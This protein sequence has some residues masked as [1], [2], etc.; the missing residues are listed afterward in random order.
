MR[1]VQTGPVTGL[2]A[3]RLSRSGAG[4][5][6]PADWVT[7]AR[8]TLTV[9]VAA[10]VVESLHRAVP[11]ALLVSFAAMAL[12]LDAVDG[13]VAR[14]T[15]TTVFGARLD[16]EVDAFLIAVLSVYVARSV[17]GWVLTIGLAR[18]VFGAA[19]WGPRGLRAPLPPRHWRKVVCAI[20][21]IVLT[22]AAADVLPP[23]LTR[24]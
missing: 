18:Y 15:R 3:G 16:G 6:G 9:A 17:G 7:L 14:R 22:V 4:R 8:G 13:W 11:V 1:T 21:G 10:L 20:Q 12:V 24:V 19:G 23:S 5:L 2:M